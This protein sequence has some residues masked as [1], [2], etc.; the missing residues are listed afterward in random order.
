M[1]DGTGN[2]AEPT[3][4][5]AASHGEAEADL[6]RLAL[7]G[8]EI[9]LKRRRVR[10]TIL[11]ELLL[12]TRPARVLPPAG[13]RLT[14]AIIEGTLDLDGC[15]IAKPVLFRHCR[16]E[17]TTG[18]PA[19]ILRDA[20][21]KRLGIHS[22][23]VEGDIQ[24]D[25]VDA[26]NGF[27]IGGGAIKGVVSVRGATIGGALSL[28]NAEFGDG[29]LALLGTGLRLK[30][31]L[32][33]RRSR[34][35]GTV[36]VPRAH[37]ESGIAGDG[38]RI[39]ADGLALDGES[40]RIGG[41]V[42][43]SE[44][45]FKGGLSLAN[46]RLEGRL[47]A[48]GAVLDNLPL[49]LDA[50]GLDVS[51][52]I[53]LDNARLRGT[54]NF[55][56]ANIGKAFRAEGIEID[57]GETAISA[58]VIR[59]GGNWELPRAKLIGQL[60]FPGARIEGQ[61]RLTEARLFG[62]DIALRAD[63]AQI[64]GGCFLSRATVLGLVRFPA[65]EIGNQLRMRGA[66]I[67]VE[68][69][70]ALLA[71]GTT[72]SRDIEL[73]DGFETAGAI[74]LDQVHVAGVLDLRGSRL[75]SAAIA[76]GGLPAPLTG[77]GNRSDEIA[78]SL[79]D[80]HLNRLVM[81]SRAADR[82]RGIVD[83]S[84]S[85]AGSFEDYADAWPPPLPLRARTKEGRDIDHM[86]L[87][88][89]TYDHLSNPAGL[90]SGDAQPDHGART[91]DRV[92][93]RRIRW[94]DGQ[95]QADVED[96]FRPQAWVGLSQRL[97]QQGFGDDALRIDIARRRRERRSANTTTAARWQSRLLDWLALY[98]HN[99]WRTVVWMA[100]VVILFAGVWASAARLCQEPGCFDESV[101]V[102]R[103]K[104]AYREENFKKTYPAFH[105]LAYSFDVFVPF[106]AFGYEDHWR[107]NLDYGP[108]AELPLPFEARPLHKRGVA[109]AKEETLA[110]TI[111]GV[112]Y[113]LMIV[114]AV[115]GLILTSLLVTGFTGLLKGRS[116]G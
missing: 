6:A 68:S 60:T 35:S 18:E 53:L 89:F 25:R 85:R 111:G 90:A 100:A 51:H 11:R 29:K 62:H 16:F 97:S 88:G 43:L 32:I 1:G 39:S 45:E 82:P 112:L 101:F 27:Y 84:R 65:C 94:L 48:N 58:D 114:E 20:R 30:G 109:I 28:E 71:P 102:V 24:A 4:D 107:P 40:A 41:D 93:Q 72:F 86:L 108:I 9:D 95:P 99:P 98:G 104:D 46:A 103:N 12:E 7:T 91:A 74:V 23:T 61:L 34:I 115:L 47:T 44:A 106:V 38:L 50:R 76:R 64:R 79:V 59:I 37:L 8:E 54:A 31:P 66:T 5:T 17:A 33:L 81:P 19:I 87:D 77:N 10:A 113:V 67:K 13:L 110:I 21:V 36:S 70:T 80:A 116:E 3:A 83:L 22:S 69:G 78:L 49:A 75:V 105:A 2:I 56:G 14:G 52:G 96:R 26:E 55:E 42:L 15:H 92:A 73:T 57:G 63:G